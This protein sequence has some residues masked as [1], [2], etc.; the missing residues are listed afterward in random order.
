MIVDLSTHP[1]RYVTVPDLIDHLGLSRDLVYWHIR[2][3]HLEVVRFAP[4]ILRIETT[5]A[6]RWAELYAFPR[7]SQ[8]QKL[9]KPPQ[10]LVATHS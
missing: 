9:H 7:I 6:R 4:R 10:S 5:E 8:R 1:R 2:V 3:G